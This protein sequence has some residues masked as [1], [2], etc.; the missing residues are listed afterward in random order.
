MDLEGEQSP[1]FSLLGE[2][3]MNEHD[4]LLR[5]VGRMESEIKS[6]QVTLEEVRKDLK[7]VRR[8]FDE[9][10]GGTRFLMGA[11]ATC[12]AVIAFLIEY[13]LKK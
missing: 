6:L 12:G 4:D 3:S 10:R 8:S 11:A 13:F 7:E 1:S 9:L 2:R 5:D